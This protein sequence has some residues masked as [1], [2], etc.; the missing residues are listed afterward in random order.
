MHTSQTKEKLELKETQEAKETAK[1][2]ANR[3]AT[4]RA[5][6]ETKDQET[7]SPRKQPPTRDPRGYTEAKNKE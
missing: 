3:D 6:K 7:E 1:R 4:I 5:R 2:R